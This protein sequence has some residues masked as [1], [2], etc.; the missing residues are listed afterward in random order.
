[1]TV[2]IDNLATDLKTE[3]AAAVVRP[4][5]LA[6]I[7]ALFFGP[8]SEA[9]E[10]ACGNALVS[11]SENSQIFG[12]L[13]ACMPNV[14]PKLVD[15][16]FAEE[17]ARGEELELNQELA[18]QVISNAT[19]ASPFVAVGLHAQD[20][21]RR[22]ETMLASQNEELQQF[23]TT[24]IANCAEAEHTEWHAD[25]LTDDLKQ[26]RRQQQLQEKVEK[27]KAGGAAAIETADAAD[28]AKDD[29]AG[30]AVSADKPAA[31]AAADPAS[32]L[33]KGNKADEADDV[34]GNSGDEYSEDEWEADAVKEVEQ[35]IYV[36]TGDALELL[37]TDVSG[38]QSIIGV[39]VYLSHTL[40]RVRR[41]IVDS[42]VL[43]TLSWMLD[44]RSSDIQKQ[45]F[46]ALN[47]IRRIGVS[48]PP[49][50]PRRPR[51]QDGSSQAASGSSTPAS[52]APVRRG[53]VLE[54]PVGSPEPG[55]MAATS[56]GQ[57]GKEGASGPSPAKSEQSEAEEVMGDDA[58][59]YFERA[60]AVCFGFVYG[61]CVPVLQSLVASLDE[62]T[63]KYASALIAWVVAELDDGVMKQLKLVMRSH[64]DLDVRVTVGISL[65]YVRCAQLVLTWS[66]RLCCS[67]IGAQNLLYRCIL[68]SR[69]V[70]VRLLQLCFESSSIL[71]EFLDGGLAHMF[72]LMR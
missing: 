8:P 58:L 48:T 50:S 23:G 62:N 64:S 29:P 31:A 36:P 69:Y 11:L 42:E 47:A 71:T 6:R 40:Q 24:I 10:E 19:A 67:V 46:R 2:I 41:Y 38:P 28:E 20:L 60:H 66:G 55:S 53:S 25:A 26:I 49:S 17:L 1:M 45:A 5:V 21:L 65:F 18:L 15:I 63:Q 43:L 61:G 54:F 39:P 32:A 52:V 37:P 7:C 33:D 27:A 3:T 57:A 70:L 44:H 51:S 72:S 68:M 59:D 56:A 22:F 4:G 9:I 16:A 35:W 34:D 30:A 12:E 14:L 13:I